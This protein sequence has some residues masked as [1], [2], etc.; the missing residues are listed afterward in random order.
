[1][2]KYISLANIK[3]ERK[4]I[5]MIK[6]YCKDK[7][8]DPK[9][10]FVYFHAEALHIGFSSRTIKHITLKDTAWIATHDC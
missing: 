10:M 3:I 5:S 8:L 2:K 7:Q 9:D 1:M 6:Q 4:T